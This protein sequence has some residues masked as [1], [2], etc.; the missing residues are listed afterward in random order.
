MKNINDFYI[1]GCRL[2]CSGYRIQNNVDNLMT[3]EMKKTFQ[4]QKQGISES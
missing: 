2:K 3:Q 1:K 4:E